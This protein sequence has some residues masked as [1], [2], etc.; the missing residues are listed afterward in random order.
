MTLCNLNNEVDVVKQTINHGCHVSIVYNTLN[1]C[2]CTM[3][4]GIKKAHNSMSCLLFLFFYRLVTIWLCRILLVAVVF[5]VQTV[6]F[7]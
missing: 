2:L 7:P 3:C 1:M 6:K 4:I 5:Y